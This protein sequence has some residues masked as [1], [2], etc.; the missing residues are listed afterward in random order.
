M[1]T[2]EEKQVNIIDPILLTQSYY[3]GHQLVFKFKGHH[4]SIGLFN[5]SKM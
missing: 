5:S 2:D 3:T 4:S 1:H